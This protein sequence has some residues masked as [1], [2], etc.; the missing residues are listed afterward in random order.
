MKQKLKDV[1][2]ANEA[3]RQ[4][5]EQSG[6]MRKFINVIK[7]SLHR[8]ADKE[9]ANEI[10]EKRKKKIKLDK[11][12]KKDISSKI[13]NAVEKSIEDDKIKVSVDMGNTCT[14]KNCNLITERF[15]ELYPKLRSHGAMV[16]DNR[17]EFMIKE[18]FGPNYQRDVYPRIYYW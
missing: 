10:F 12:Y 14:S 2:D 9:R 15:E 7:S 4:D 5:F 1:A 18:K 11:V 17:C 6:I 8:D 13:N 16:V 3:I